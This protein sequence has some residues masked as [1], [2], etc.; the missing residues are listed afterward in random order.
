M[1]KLLFSAMLLLGS[2]TSMAQ[3]G[4]DIKFD[5][6]THNFG[7]VPS[8][9]AKVHCTFTFTNVGDE[10]LVINQAYASCGC[11]VPEFTKEPILPG[12]SGVIKVSYDRRRADKGHFRKNITVRT[13]AKV[14]SH[15]LTIEGDN[16]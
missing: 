12:Q 8:D 4:A 14:E 1:K 9:S 7:V 2:M 11:T 16:E 3:E 10:P 15:R 13:N 5:T 6:Q